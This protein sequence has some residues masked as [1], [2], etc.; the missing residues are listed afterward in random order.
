MNVTMNLVLVGYR[1]TGK[2]TI[3]RELSTVLSMPLLSL[4]DELVRRADQS[5]A[6]IVAA[7]GWSHFR[8][9]EQALVAELTQQTGRILDCG[10]GVVERPANVTAL[11]ACGTVFWLTA[12]ATTIVRRIADGTERPALTST[13]SFTEEVETVLTRR[14]PLYQALAHVRIDTEAAPPENLAR[15]IRSLWPYPIAPQNLP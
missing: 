14:N 10:G 9:L 7:E 8:D 15:Q 13:M 12:S 6:Q 4:D 3:A 2:S 11:R 1:G 5:I